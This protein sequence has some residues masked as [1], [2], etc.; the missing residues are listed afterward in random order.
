MRH[1]V[2]VVNKLT[3]KDPPRSLYN[4]FYAAYEAYWVMYG[5]PPS[6]ADTRRQRMTYL[7]TPTRP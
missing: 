2:D 5:L 7:T 3:D 1:D 6:P 4:F